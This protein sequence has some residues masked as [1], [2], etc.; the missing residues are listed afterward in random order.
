MNLIRRY[1][2]NALVC[3]VC[4]AKIDVSTS[5]FLSSLPR[6]CSVLFRPKFARSLLCGSMVSACFKPRLRSAC[7]RTSPS[8]CRSAR[9][10][11]EEERA[12]CA[13]SSPFHAVIRQCVLALAQAA[14]DSPRHHRL[15][16]RVHP[17]GLGQVQ[18]A[19]PPNHLE[20]AHKHVRL[21]LFLL[22]LFMRITFRGLFV[23]VVTPCPMQC[24]SCFGCVLPDSFAVACH[25]R[26][27][28]SD[29]TDA[30]FG[31]V[32]TALL[33]EIKVGK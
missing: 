17:R 16:S 26:C 2:G 20:P 11:C 33:E 23:V 31:A 21:L 30:G 19:L 6:L 14:A 10:K 4:L 8:L 5:L 12:Y 32:L 7:W 9:F 24:L 13:F 3:Q 22:H 15:C 25:S 28:N 1:P 18:S 29:E 27:L